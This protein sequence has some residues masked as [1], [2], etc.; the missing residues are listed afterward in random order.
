[1]LRDHQSARADITPPSSPR[2]D[3]VHLRAR[4]SPRLIALGVLAIVLG[5]L[6]AAALYSMNTTVTSVIV[7]AR[8]VVR[9]D[10]IEADDLA[11]TDVPG[12]L[13]VDTLSSDRL[14]DVIGLSALSDLPA[15]SF[16]LQRHFG[17]EPIP[18]GHALVGLRLAA[19][20]LPSSAL[21]PGTRV[22]LIG[23]TEGD[24][25]VVDALMASS[26]VLLDDGSGH[27]LD[28]TVAND[29][30]AAVAALAATDQLALISVGDG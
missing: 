17:Q 3:A 5:A 16:P 9:G 2:P 29:V 14:H 21:P 10:V 27:L 30:A 1:M 26:P 4:R 7:V 11:T 23:L 24:D 20:R 12:S 19:G 13:Q 8:D 6:G 28:V 18:R 25:T 15:G 22:Q